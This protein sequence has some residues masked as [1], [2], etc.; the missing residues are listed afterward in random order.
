MLQGDEPMLLDPA[1][2]R[3]PSASFEG[4][5]RTSSDQPGRGGSRPVSDAPRQGR[6]RGEPVGPMSTYRLAVGRR[7][8]ISPRQIVG[9]LANEGGLSGDD[10]GKIDI[11]IDHTLVDLPAK[12]PKE[13]WEKLRTTRISGKL[14]EMERDHGVTG[15]SWKKGRGQAS[16]D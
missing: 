2:N 9:A 10:F 15:K 3:T 11:R 7:H 6:T 14:I 5:S 8:K 1:A 4:P 12:L 13:V 16:R